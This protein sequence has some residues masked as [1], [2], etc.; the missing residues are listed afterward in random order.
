MVSA[1]A[2]STSRIGARIGLATPRW[3]R[4]RFRRRP[5]RPTSCR[6]EDGLRAIHRRPRSPARRCAACR[7]DAEGR[8]WLEIPGG[9]R[10]ELI[11][12]TDRS[13][14]R[15]SRRRRVPPLRRDAV[16]CG[17]RRSVRFPISTAYRRRRVH[18]AVPAPPRPRVRRRPRADPAVAG[19]AQPL[20]VEQQH[21]EFDPRA[22]P[23]RPVRAD[24][25]TTAAGWAEY[26]SIARHRRRGASFS[27]ASAPR[28]PPARDLRRGLPRPVRRAD[29][30][31]T[32]GTIENAALAA[33]RGARARALH[34][35]LAGRGRS[36]P[37]PRSRRT[38]IPSTRR[39]QRSRRGGAAAP[40]DVSDAHGR[41]VLARPMP[42]AAT[43][44]WS[45]TGRVGAAAW[46]Q[47]TY[48]LPRGGP[49][50]RRCRRPLA[51]AASARAARYGGWSPRLTHAAHWKIVELEVAPE[52]AGC[53]RHRS[54]RSCDRVEHRARDGG[55]HDPDAGVALGPRPRPTASPRPPRRPRRS[56]A[57]SGHEH[58][59]VVA[60][61]SGAASDPTRARQRHR[62]GQHQAQPSRCVDATTRSRRPGARAGRRGPHVVANLHRRRRSCPSA[63]RTTRRAA[64]TARRARS[65]ASPACRVARL[66]WRAARTDRRAAR[67]LHTRPLCEAWRRDR[68]RSSSAVAAEATGA[69]RPPAARAAATSRGS[70]RRRVGSEGTAR[71]RIRTAAAIAARRRSLSS[72]PGGSCAT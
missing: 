40:L 19:R 58:G 51:R 39:G 60:A 23:R 57:C 8:L 49:A 30:A 25:R 20:V 70:T 62:V 54:R 24:A 61:R 29:R 13:R 55:D 28:E 36:R 32:R 31:T 64:A 46:P 2:M 21:A 27:A 26:R 35:R 14:H 52:R 10:F 17:T 16:R 11:T 37:P 66:F 44:A 12:S 3:P 42:G 68:C 43:P 45:W 65:G 7:T 59:D 22:G 15:E 47:E 33:P 69:R 5:P 67:R 63:D 56:A 4:S 9:A 34:A 72:A 48:A 18:A 50:A 41:R 53:A 38:P 71:Q 1:C 6:A